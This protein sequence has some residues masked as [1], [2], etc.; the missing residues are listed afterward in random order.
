MG[1]HRK[2]Y[3]FCGKDAFVEKNKE[4]VMESENGFAK[5]FSD[6]GFWDKALKFSKAAGKEVIEKALISY[7]ALQSSDTPA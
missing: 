6:A 4:R 7:Y 1:C 3:G 2:L 5:E